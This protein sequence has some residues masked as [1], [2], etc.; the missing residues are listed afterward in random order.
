MRHVL[1][2]LLLLVALLACASALNAQV[3]AGNEG[4]VAGQDQQGWEDDFDRLGLLE[5][6]E[7]EGW[8]QAYDDIAD[9]AANKMDINTCRREDLERLPFLSAQQVMDIIEY[10]DRVGRIV[11]TAELSLIPSMEKTDVALLE[12]LIYVGDPAPMDTLPS[13]RSLFSH[14][15]NELM[16]TLRVPLY[17]R[18]GDRNGYLGYKYKHWLRYTFTAGQRLK[19]GLVA[20]QDAGEPFF[21]GKNS[22]GYDFYS[23]Y[24]L[25]R[26]VK[27]LKALALGRYRLRFG[28]GLVMNSSFNLGKLITLS[29]LGRSSNS[30][31]AYS[32]RSEANYL[33]GAAATVRVAR[34]LDL[35]AFASYR[36]IDAT[37][38]KDSSTVATILTTG[39][40][41]TQSEMARR[42]NTS[43]TVLGGNATFRRNGFNVGATA[44]WTSF[45]RELRP[46]TTQAYRRWYPRGKRFFNASVDYGYVSARLNV[47]G[48]TAAD[49]HGNVAT[50]N[51]VSYQ[52]ADNFSLMALQRFYPYQ[53][54]P[55]FGR[56]FAEGGRA[57]NESG[58][59]LGGNWQPWHNATLSFYSDYAYHAWP[60]FR[61]SG[62]SHSWDNFVQLS[63]TRRRWT[64]LMRYRLRRHEQDTPANDEGTQRLAWRNDHRARFAATYDG[65]VLSAR[66]QVDFSHSRQT[67][68]STGWMVTENV[69]A[70]LGMVSLNATVGYFHTDDY[71]SRVYAYERG[72]LSTFSFPSFQGEG[73]RY[74]LW[75]RC[76]IGKSLTAIAKV[77]VTDYF[78][79]SV[80]STG[81]QQI[82]RSSQTDIDLQVR[83]RF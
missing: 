23:F 66:T 17:E 68:G 39:L 13:M 3:N 44:L 54:Y 65:S 81:L 32:S 7:D 2:K 72:T 82:D 55:I 64:L 22:L 63:M 76:D 70:K 37:L 19:A 12:K 47:S 52:F 78:D 49:Q 58:L 1:C 26:D 59:F 61:V 30:V 14:G 45:N 20:S 71:Y 8:E 6:S 27:R 31:S 67:V 56:S 53:Y 34:G 41:R 77:G 69:F 79:R 83:W 46:S 51:S 5:D 35:T 15:R 43:E 48:E 42:R 9:I 73:I 40:H 24:F 80:I 62:S 25:L 75:G 36:K 33:Q 10:R 16:G 4:G 28:M 11:T 57:N 29:M 18:Q 50:V 60:R 21:A 74:A 38:N